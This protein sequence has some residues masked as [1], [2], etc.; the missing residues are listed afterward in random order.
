MKRINLVVLVILI[1]IP[2]FAK[3]PGDRVDAR[4]VDLI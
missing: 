1:S 4:T 2:A 3:D